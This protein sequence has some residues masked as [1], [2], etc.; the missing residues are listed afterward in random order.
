MALAYVDEVL[1]KGVPISRGGE[2]S[3][4]NGCKILYRSVL[5]PVGEDENSISGILGAANC[6]EVVEN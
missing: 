1:I 3:S 5:L 6:R 4:P 2:F